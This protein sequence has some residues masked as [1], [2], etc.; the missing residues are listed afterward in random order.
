M[1]NDLFLKRLTDVAEWF[2][3]KETGFS[4]NTPKSLKR[5]YA[6]LAAKVD[7]EEGSEESDTE[8]EQSEP[9]KEVETAP[10]IVR[11]HPIV[12]DCEDCGKKKVYDRVVTS[13]L[14]HGPARNYWKH[15]CSSCKSY[16]NPYTGEYSLQDRAATETFGIYGRNQGIQK[17]G[18]RAL[19]SLNKIKSKINESLPE[20]DK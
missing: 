2:R 17:G 14:L 18:Q 6:Q 11:I 12:K 15:H 20:T 1:D 19:M 7:T 5:K 16:K 4:V 10:R 9:L 3:P 8:D 13:K